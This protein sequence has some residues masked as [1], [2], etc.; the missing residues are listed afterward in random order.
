MATETEPVLDLNTALNVRRN[1]RIDGVNYPL[2]SI[3]EFSIRD[4]QRQGEQFGRIGQLSRVAKLSRGQE[5]EQKRIV[6]ELLRAVLIAPTTVHK[7][8]MVGQKMAILAV[9]SQL[10]SGATDSL[11]GAAQAARR[12]LKTRNRSG[13]R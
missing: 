7:R 13:R 8:L 12:I 11:P 4:Y 10:L 3:D 9:F 6:D 2:R 1:V 5:K